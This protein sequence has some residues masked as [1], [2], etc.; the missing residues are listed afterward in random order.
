MLNFPDPSVE[1]EYTD[2]NGSV[3]VFN[4]TGWMR[5]PDCLDGGGGGGGVGDLGDLLNQGCFETWST[6]YGYRIGGDEANHPCTL[7][8]G[9]FTLQWWVKSNTNKFSLFNPASTTG[10]NWGV[11]IDD[12]GSLAFCWN[13]HIEVIWRWT[14]TSIIDGRWH[15]IRICRTN[16]VHSLYIDGDEKDIGSPADG[17]RDLSGLFKKGACWGGGVVGGQSKWTRYAGFQVVRGYSMGAPDKHLELRRP[18]APCKEAGAENLLCVN[19]PESSEQVTELVD[20]GDY[21]NTVVIADPA[22]GTTHPVKDSPYTWNPPI[23][24]LTQ[25]ELDEGLE[26]EIVPRPADNDSQTMDIDLGLLGDDE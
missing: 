10:N 18:F 26:K 9:D 3:W 19:F 20:L 11:Y 13:Y 15:H 1:T 22:W 2:P 14:A 24:A 17:G 21:G 6:K 23:R 25:K 12:A 4:G 8:T 7:G 5:Q 16:G